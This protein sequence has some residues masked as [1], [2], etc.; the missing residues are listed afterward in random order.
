M[1]LLAIFFAFLAD[2]YWREKRD[3]N[4]APH[5][6]VGEA[7]EIGVLAG[8]SWLGWAALAL[9]IAGVTIGADI[10]V[11]GGVAVARNAGVSEAVIGLTLFAVGTSLPELAV[12]I[13][14][15]AR[16][17]ADVALGN[18]VGS[19]LFNVLGIVGV[20]AVVVPLP[21]P[22]QIQKFDLWVMLGASLLLVPYL[23]G[24]RRLGR[25]EAAAILAAYGVYIAAQGYGVSNLFRSL[26]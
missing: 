10:L 25:V 18:V 2:A 13:Q 16:G 12:S 19:N 9:G 20:M 11:T 24:R 5:L 21:V 17:H 7:R 4:A 26:G 23:I 1:L 14:A 8:P 3:G 22:D 15:A 6:H